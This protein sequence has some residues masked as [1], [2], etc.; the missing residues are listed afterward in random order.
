M[1]DRHTA[2]S[3]TAD[4]LDQLYAERDQYAARLLDVLYVAE[5]IDANGIGWAASSV[6]RAATGEIAAYPSTEETR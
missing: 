5:V 6:R 2:D 1:A 4:Q 3:I